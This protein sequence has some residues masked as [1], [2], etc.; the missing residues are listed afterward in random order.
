MEEPTA[1]VPQPGAPMSGSART[2]L[3]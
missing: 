2:S 3:R 1:G